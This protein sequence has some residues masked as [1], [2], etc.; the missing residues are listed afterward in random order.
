MAAFVVAFATFV[1]ALAHW[2]RAVVA[3]SEADLASRARLTASALYEPIRTLDFKAIDAT[4]AQ[5]KAEGKSY[6]K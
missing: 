1:F 4:A 3:W 2:W 5:L 6:G